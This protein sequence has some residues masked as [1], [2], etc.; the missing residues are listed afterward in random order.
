M[1]KAE[2]QLHDAAWLNDTSVV[3]IAPGGRRIDWQWQDR[4]CRGLGMVLNGED[5]RPLF[6]ALFNTGADNA[7]F[8]LPDGAWKVVLSSAPD[9]PSAS[10]GSV[11]LPAFSAVFA[12]NELS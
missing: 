10:A 9:A 3:W 5:G 11:A 8:S 1:R 12:R 4:S 6:A 7:L 2:L